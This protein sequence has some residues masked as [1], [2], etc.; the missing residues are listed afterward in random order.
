MWHVGL[1]KCKRWQRPYKQTG[2]A[3][4]AHAAERTAAILTCKQV[5]KSYT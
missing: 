3:G 4:A 2:G 1:A 5:L